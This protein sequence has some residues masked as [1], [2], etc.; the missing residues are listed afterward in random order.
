MSTS[1]DYAHADHVRLCCAEPH[2]LRLLP[3]LTKA[4]GSHVCTLADP[5]HGWLRLREHA[6]FQDLRDVTTGPIPRGD[7]HVLVRA[8][9]ELI[10]AEY[11]VR[12]TLTPG[13]PGVFVTCGGRRVPLSSWLEDPAG[14]CLVVKDW[15]ASQHGLTRS[16]TDAWHAMR[17]ERVHTPI[18]M[19]QEV[20][21]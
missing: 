10:K 19:D 16:D 13:P 1:I 14:D 18:A 2:S 3:V 12:C 21:S 20:A 17:R 4:V 5:A 7:R 6:L 8:F 11:L 9:Q 15:V